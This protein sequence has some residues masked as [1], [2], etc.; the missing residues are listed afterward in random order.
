[1]QF[2]FIQYMN[3]VNNFTITICDCC[4]N[5][6]RVF[7][8]YYNIVTLLAKARNHRQCRLF[9]VSNFYSLRLK[10]EVQVPH[11]E[12]YGNSSLRFGCIVDNHFLPLS[13]LQQNID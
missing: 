1:M 13:Y 5:I 6:C 10:F 11:I 7:D 9:I 8:K 3:I 2:N 12:D 4:E